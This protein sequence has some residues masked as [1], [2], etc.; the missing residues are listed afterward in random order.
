[1]LIRDGRQL[2][3]SPLDIRTEA[4]IVEVA[5][6]LEPRPGEEVLDAHGGLVLPGLHDH[7]VHIRAAAAAA[8]SVRVGPPQV[9]THAE[10]FA[11][12]AAADAG[13]D[14][15][16]RAVGYH[17]SVAGSLDR[18]ALDAICP[19]T[20]VR[21]QHRSGVL[22][23]LNSAALA[24]IGQPEHLDGRLRSAD[25][26]WTDALPRRD[27][28]LSALG[29]QLA[30]WGVTGITDATPELAP[31]AADELTALPQRIYALSP[32]KRILHD[33]RLDLDELTAW[34]RATHDAGTA[35][36]VHCVTVSQ[37][38][39]AMAAL[40]SAG[41][42]RGDRIEH[43]AL[44]P[45]DCLADLADLG[46]TVVTQPNFI[47]E[48]GEEYLAEVPA[49]EHGQLWRVRTLV[50]AGVPVAFSTDM[51]FGYG[52]PWA[53]MRAAVHRRTPVGHIIGSDECVSPRTAL[54]MFLGAP[55]APAAAR[56]L[57][58]GRPGDLCVLSAPPAAVLAEL[59]AG[60]VRAT[61]VA[62]R[63]VYGR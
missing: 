40:R 58:P 7:H 44:V 43:A 9:R 50:D 51:P 62:G 31:L 14:G 12:L 13:A 42:H 59:D 55:D 32:G 17:D 30:S 48:R 20:P 21:V 36:A 19:T 16:I 56:T 18:D 33:D 61:L 60:L 1:M 35:V 11:A 37:L 5:A 29:V 22:W 63:L 2:D 3:D 52:D 10:L 23:T 49:E 24:A 34:V 47:A 53:A 8:G 39:V 57:A 25:T 26:G 45:P 38:V 27:G 6:I 54:E 46:V 41:V 28:G 4:T 15:W